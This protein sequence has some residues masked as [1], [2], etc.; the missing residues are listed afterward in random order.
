MVTRSRPKSTSIRASCRQSTPRMPSV[1][2]NTAEGSTGRRWFS[3]SSSP[4]CSVATSTTGSVALPVTPCTLI[5]S[6]SAGTS[7]SASAVAADIAER[8]APV[9]ST[10][11]NG[12]RPL[13]STL[14]TMRPIRSSV[15]RVAYIGPDSGVHADGRGRIGCPDR[16]PEQQQHATSRDGGAPTLRVFLGPYPYDRSRGPIRLQPPR[17]RVPPRRLCSGSPARRH[18]IAGDGHSRAETAHSRAIGSVCS[19]PNQRHVPEGEIMRIG[20]PKE[21]KVH[22]YRVG[23]VPAGRPRAGRSRPRGAG[24]R[25]A[26]RPASASPTPTTSASARRSRRTRR[27]S[28]PKSEMI[29]KVKEPQPGEC[30][31][32]RAGQVLYTYL[33]LAPDPRQTAGA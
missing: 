20:V 30:A 16:P 23:L 12:P 14:A 13:I 19:G 24:A 9:S 33:H 28:S 18:L 1:P 27:R 25:P 5:T 32:L 15:V 29:V 8:L 31:M 22:E 17:G 26:P 4:A 6:P 10:K 3:N 2:A 21:I 11:R 7:C